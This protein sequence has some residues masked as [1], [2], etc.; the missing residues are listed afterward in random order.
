MGLR[1][2]TQAVQHRLMDTRDAGIEGSKDRDQKN[3]GFENQRKT[4][5]KEL[6]KNPGLKNKAGPKI[7]TFIEIVLGEPPNTKAL[8]GVVGVARMPR[9]RPGAARVECGA[10]GPWFDPKTLKPANTSW[11]ATHL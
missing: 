2:P 7:G 4:K 6:K 11:A 5:I 10:C 3:P 9:R 1:W 8:S